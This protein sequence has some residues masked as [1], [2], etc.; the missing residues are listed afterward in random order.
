MGYYFISFLTKHGCADIHPDPLVSS[1]GHGLATQ[2][3]A[4]PDVEDKTVGEAAI[5]AR[6]IF[7]SE[8]GRSL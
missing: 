2:T 8:R 1:L 3:R 5:N 4:A 6:R 7:E